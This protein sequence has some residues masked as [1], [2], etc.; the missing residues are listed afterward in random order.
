MDIKPKVLGLIN[1]WENRLLGD[2]TNVE[3]KVLGELLKKIGH[4]KVENNRCNICTK[5]C[6]Q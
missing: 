3:R 5:D 6:C 1:E 2:L 4:A